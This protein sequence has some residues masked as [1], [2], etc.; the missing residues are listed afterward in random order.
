MRHGLDDTEE[1]LSERIARHEELERVV[2]D[3]MRAKIAESLSRGRNA[4]A[5]AYA[6]VLKAA[7]AQRGEI[8]TVD[9]LLAEIGRTTV[10]E[11]ESDAAFD[12][13]PDGHHEPQ[14]GAPTRHWWK[15][16]KWVIPTLIGAGS[17]IVGLLAL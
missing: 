4:Q 8:V 1:T 17:L 7:L 10:T 15:D 11:G 13:S 5:R 14:A 12:C 9:E 16:P 2:P 3:E 6:K